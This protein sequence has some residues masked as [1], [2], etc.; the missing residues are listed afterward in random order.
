MSPE[1]GLRVP[2]QAVEVERHVVGAMLLDAE[3]MTTALESL[4]PDDFYLDAHRRMFEAI[5]GL[6][7][8]N[9]RADLITVGEALRKAGTFEKAGGMPA[10]MEISA[11]VVSSA[12]VAEHC[13]IVKEKSMLRRLIGSATKILERAYDGNQEPAAIHLFPIFAS[14]TYLN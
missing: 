4:A 10:L 9:A 6:F 12:N 14:K 5:A 13:R 11:E 8:K 7:E 2:P 1:S 3:A